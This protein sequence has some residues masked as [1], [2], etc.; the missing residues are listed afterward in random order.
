MSEVDEPDLQGL[1]AEQLRYVLSLRRIASDRMVRVSSNGKFPFGWALERWM[2]VLTFVAVVIGGIWFG[3]GEWRG[4]KLMIEDH[5]RDL[6]QLVVKMNSVSLHLNQL[7]N[8]VDDFRDPPL[9][10]L[11]PAPPPVTPTFSRE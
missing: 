4:V 1:N 11:A 6:E 9:N 7:Q 5:G 2:T 10:Q 8:Q 3:G